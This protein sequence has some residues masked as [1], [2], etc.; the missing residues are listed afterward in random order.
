LGITLNIVDPQGTSRLLMTT[1]WI[2]PPGGD[3]WWA[4][5]FE[6]GVVSRGVGLLGRAGLAAGRAPS[7]RQPYSLGAEL[8]V[9]SFHL[10]YAWQAFHSLGAA[11]RFGIR[12][13]R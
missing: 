7:D 4:F 5:G 8:V 10:E 13:E 6:G 1:D 11:H 2:A 12:W 3:S 9:R